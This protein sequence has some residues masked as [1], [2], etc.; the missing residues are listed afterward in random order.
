MRLNFLYS[1]SLE[2]SLFFKEIKHDDIYHFVSM[3]K[4]RLS[5]GIVPK[6]Y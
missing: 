1:K 3:D 5:H 2:E 6:K 4:F